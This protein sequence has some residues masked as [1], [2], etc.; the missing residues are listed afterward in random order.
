MERCLLIRKSS[1]V[2]VATS[3]HSRPP[4]QSSRCIRQGPSR[5]FRRHPAL[6][7]GKSG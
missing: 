2:D 3:I 7:P 6:P 5:S 4:E 1:S